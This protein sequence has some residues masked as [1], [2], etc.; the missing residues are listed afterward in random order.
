[1]QNNANKSSIEFILLAALRVFT[2]ASA[3]LGYYGR[4]DLYGQNPIEDKL[5]TEIF[6]EG[7]VGRRC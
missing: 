7:S 1:M 5:P 3:Q 6:I 4:Y 2:E